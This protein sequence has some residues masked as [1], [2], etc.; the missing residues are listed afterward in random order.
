MSNSNIATSGLKKKTFHVES[1]A[2]MEN[3]YHSY[4]RNRICFICTRHCKLRI[5]N[6]CTNY[7]SYDLR[8]IVHGIVCEIIVDYGWAVMRWLESRN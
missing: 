1:L 8:D 7:C 2:K 3:Y 4:V 5:V 6:L